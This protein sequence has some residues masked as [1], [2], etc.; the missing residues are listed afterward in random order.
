M[1]VIIINR[2]VGSIP[3]PRGGAPIKLTGGTESWLIHF[4]VRRTIPDAVYLKNKEL[5]DSL[6]KKRQIQLWV[7]KEIREQEVPA[8]VEVAP[9]APPPVKETDL[10]SEAAPAKE[11]NVP[12]TPGSD[13]YDEKTRDELLALCDERGVKAPRRNASKSVLAELL[14][15]ADAQ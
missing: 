7:K 8:F 12:E 5:L 13:M 14:R 4:G 3:V 2:P 6:R 9:A 1:S 11:E 15:D 10:E